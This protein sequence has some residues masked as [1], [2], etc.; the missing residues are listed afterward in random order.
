MVNIVYV[1]NI[2]AENKTQW[3]KLFETVEQM[4]SFVI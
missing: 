1:L 4:F 2:D 3:R